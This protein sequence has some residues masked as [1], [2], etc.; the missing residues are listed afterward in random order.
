MYSMYLIIILN[1]S[2]QPSP[3]PLIFTQQTESSAK[4]REVARTIVAQAKRNLPTG[5]RVK[6][7]RVECKFTGNRGGV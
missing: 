5:V 7:Q 6:T 3:S 1:S 2:G 4:C